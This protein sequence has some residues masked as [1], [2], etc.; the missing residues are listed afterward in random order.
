MNLFSI[1]SPSMIGDAALSAV[2][3]LFLQEALGRRVGGWM[4]GWVGG[5]DSFSWIGK[6]KIFKNQS[7]R[8]Q[9][10]IGTHL[11]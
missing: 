5:R 11:F 10:S 6:S 4:G 7:D 2:F 3:G 1:S 8:S 9:T